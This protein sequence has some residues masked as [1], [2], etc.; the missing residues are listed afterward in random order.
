M[1]PDPPRA[2]GACSLCCKLLPIAALDK[3]HDKWCVHCRPGAGG[4]MVY[5]TRPEACRTFDCRWLTDAAF[6]GHWFPQTS[7]MVVQTVEVDDPAY[8]LFVD[9]HVDRGGTNAWRADPFAADL[10]TISARPRT[11][12]RI[13]QA[14]RTFIVRPGETL[15]LKRA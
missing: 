15:E 3:P 1:I 5:E 2:C 8:D 14:G 12:V 4:C 10:Q 6:G 13:F 9:V 7:K 11:L